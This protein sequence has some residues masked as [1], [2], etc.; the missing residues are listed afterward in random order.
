MFPIRNRHYGPMPSFDRRKNIEYK[1]LSCKRG[2]QTHNKT[3][4]HCPH[5]RGTRLSEINRRS[6]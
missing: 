3:A 2:F 4:T 1:C 6:A 5:C